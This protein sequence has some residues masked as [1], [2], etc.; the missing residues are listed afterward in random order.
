MFL[1][2]QLVPC[3]LSLLKFTYRVKHS[4]SHN[5]T[6][7]EVSSTGKQV[8]ERTEWRNTPV[9]YPDLL[10]LLPLQSQPTSSKV[11]LQG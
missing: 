3:G 7:A 11:H 9:N 10:S 8:M 6:I 1:S 5:V 4:L 2:M